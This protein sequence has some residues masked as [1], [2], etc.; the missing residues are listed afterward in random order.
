MS[1]NSQ[2]YR[3]AVARARAVIRDQLKGGDREPSI[4]TAIEVLRATKKIDY[5]VDDLA[6]LVVR[7][8]YGIENDD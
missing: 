6:C 1:P 8:V 4:E 7:A 5:V 3:D 2:A